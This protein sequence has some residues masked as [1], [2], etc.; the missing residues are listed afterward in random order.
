MAT[1]EDLDLEYY[2]E[3]DP[4]IIELIEEERKW[5]VI[6]NFKEFI[7]KE[8]EFLGIHNLSSQTILNIIE[9]STSNVNKKEY[10]KWQI[11]F[12]TK[13]INEVTNILPDTNLVKNV[14]DNIYYNMYI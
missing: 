7:S 14:Y 2:A 5:K 6:S 10:P 8:P 3:N 4:E 1:N 12:L 9:T 13:L 11:G